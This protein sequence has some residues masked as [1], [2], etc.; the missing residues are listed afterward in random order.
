[1]EAGV[2]ISR[3]PCCVLPFGTGNDFARCTN[4]GGTPT[5]EIFRNLGTLMREI[6]ENSSEE[7][8]NVWTVKVTYK[9]R[10]GD[11]FE[12]DS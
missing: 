8:I 7:K 11:I 3:M 9:A 10:G 6:C 1:M 5:G 12:V 2:D 4:W